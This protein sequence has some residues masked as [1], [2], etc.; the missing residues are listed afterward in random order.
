MP[1]DKPT[2]NELLMRAMGREGVEAQETER[3]RA[4]RPKVGMNEL[5]RRAAAED[6]E[7]ALSRHRIAQRYEQVAAS[8]TG[9]SADGGY[10]GS[11]PRSRISGG[12]VL[13]ALLR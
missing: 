2:M 9:G 13:N 5:L 3:E 4:E 12:A 1:D 6:P 8:R 11:A 10:R 7:A